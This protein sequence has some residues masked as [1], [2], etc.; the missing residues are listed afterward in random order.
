MQRILLGLI[1]VLILGFTSLWLLLFTSTGNGIL[2][3]WLESYIQGYVPDVKLEAFSLRPEQTR[4]TLSLKQN[5]R[6]EIDATSNLW[7][8]SALGTWRLHAT[9]L[10]EL[11]A[12]LPLALGGAMSSEGRFNITPDALAADGKLQ[13]A[14]SL[15]NF[16]AQQASASTPIQAQLSG[17][18]ALTDLW[19][20]L[21]QPKLAS[22]NLSV[23][24]SA[25]IPRQAPLKLGGQVKLTLPDGVAYHQAINQLSELQ[26]PQDQPFS[27]SSY[28]D[29]V[30]GNSLSKLQVSSPLAQIQLSDLR[31][32]LGSDDIS[33]QHETQVNDLTRLVFLTQV[34]LHGSLTTTGDALL[35]LKTK[36]LTAT[37]NSDTLGGRINAKLANQQLTATMQELSAFE[38]SRLLGMKPVFKS[39]LEGQINYHIAQQQGTFSALLSDGQILPNDVSAL[40]NQAAR[41]DITREVYKTV[42]STGDIQQKVITADLDMQ[43]RLTHITSQGARIDL[44]QQ[45]LDMLLNVAIQGLKLPVRLKGELTSPGVSADF[46][47]LL[48]QNLKQNTE[49]AA[50]EA[51]E[52]EKEKL[53][54]QFKLPKLF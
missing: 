12:L 54:Q 49:K 35:N 1:S 26:L 41:F 3:P 34:P 40:L 36:S 5:A 16:H 42:T 25:D 38:L 22:G 6:L 19:T 43:S 51:I 30:S 20:L 29:I 2:K 24:A 52:K 10:S 14:H 21:A 45:Q 8:Q 18:L 27:F 33:T 28:S 39:R 37:A 53:Q 44:S 15:L 13:L 4:F 23:S 46:T 48:Q 9:D 17:D 7:Q 32:V 50:Q 11:N 47:G 31:Y